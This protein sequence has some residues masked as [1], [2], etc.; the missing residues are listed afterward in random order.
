[1]PA[2]MRLWEGASSSVPFTALN[3]EGV[4]LLK[5][6]LSNKRLYDTPY[7]RDVITNVIRT[8]CSHVGARPAPN[9]AFV[10][11]KDVSNVFI[12][13]MDCWITVKMERASTLSAWWQAIG[14]IFANTGNPSCDLELWAVAPGQTPDP[15][16]TDPRKPSTPEVAGA[17]LGVLVIGLFVAVILFNR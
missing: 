11:W 4:Y 9:L 6:K 17:G 2:Y 10:E 15:T 5:V 16:P 3:A 1:M 12:T 14:M 13:R 7:K 8:N